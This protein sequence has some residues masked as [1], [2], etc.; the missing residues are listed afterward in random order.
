MLLTIKHRSDK[1]MYM[2]SMG[3]IVLLVFSVVG[4][5]FIGQ[6]AWHFYSKQKTIV[7]PMLFNTPF[8]TSE[9]AADPNYYRMMLYSFVALRLNVTPE[10][11]DAQ[12]KELL[13]FVS[14]VARPELEKAMGIESKIIKSTNLTSVFFI[15]HYTISPDGD[16]IVSGKLSAISGGNALPEMEKKYR[17]KMIY[18]NGVTGLIEFSEVVEK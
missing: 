11:V 8:S 13:N 4:N 17:L 7:T 16:A 10:T 6:L 15:D 2:F 5:V 3:L 18:L 9:I 12:H 14:P 1:A